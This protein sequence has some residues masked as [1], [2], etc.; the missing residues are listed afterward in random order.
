MRI[1]VV[2]L[3]RLL[4]WHFFCCFIRPISNYRYCVKV[5]QRFRF[6][7]SICIYVVICSTQ[8]FIPISWNTILWISRNLGSISL[9]L[10]PYCLLAHSYWLGWKRVHS[11]WWKGWCKNLYSFNFF[12]FLLSEITRSRDFWIV[13]KRHIVVDCIS[14]NISLLL[15][16]PCL[17]GENGV[18]KIRNGGVDR[19]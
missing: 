16:F 18:K 1:T 9:L 14:V 10:F 8:W 19:E 6:C 3:E 13:S 12:Y 2:Y 11:V 17:G 15:W 5:W 4:L 7:L